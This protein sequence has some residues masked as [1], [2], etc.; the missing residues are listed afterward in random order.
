MMCVFKKIVKTCEK[1]KKISAYMYEIQDLTPI[2]GHFRTNFKISGQRPGLWYWTNS[3]II[4]ISIE[5]VESFFCF[6]SATFLFLLGLYLCQQT[7]RSKG[8]INQSTKTHLD[9][10]A[11]HEQIRLVERGLTSHSTQFR[12]FRRRCFYRSDDPTNSVKA[13]KEGG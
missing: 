13:L 8:S 4:I 6:N 5:A 2:S 3:H 9:S 7:N 1:F 12:S 11:C 10:A